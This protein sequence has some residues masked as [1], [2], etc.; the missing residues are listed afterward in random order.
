MVSD[1]L[2][3]V[4]GLM[5]VQVSPGPPPTFSAP[6]NP[7]QIIGF[8]QLF[9]NPDGRAT[10]AWP[11]GSA[12]RVNTTVINMAGCG[13]GAAGQA[14]LGEGTSPVAVRLISPP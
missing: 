13:T 10:P 4:P 7:V 2:V 9:V 14:I 11:A 8:V 1:S 6:T 5:F 3:T 12:G